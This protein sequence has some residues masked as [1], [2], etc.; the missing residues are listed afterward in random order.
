[1]PRLDMPSGPSNVP[2]DEPNVEWSS[3]EAEVPSERTERKGQGIREKVAQRL[4]MMELVDPSLMRAARTHKAIEALAQECLGI[5][6]ESRLDSSFV[7]QEI[8]QFWSHSWHGSAW[9]K[10]L[11]VLAMENGLAATV[12]GTLAGLIAMVLYINGLLPGGA[13]PAILG[14]DHGTSL[15]LWSTAAA[16]LTALLTLCFWRPPRSV[17]L[18]ALCVDRQTPRRKAECIVS[19]GAFVKRSRTLLVLWDHTFCQ[20]LWCIFEIGA[21]LKSHEENTAARMLVRPTYLGPCVFSLALGMLLTMGIMHFIRWNNLLLAV[22]IFAGWGYF[23]FSLAV[24]AFRH[25]FESVRV[26]QRC[27]ANFRIEDALCY[28]CQKAHRRPD[29]T[30][31]ICDREIVCDCIKRWYGSAAEFEERVQSTI[32]SALTSQLGRHAFPYLWVLGSTTP[33]LWGEMDLFAAHYQANW[34]PRR[35]Y[36][37]VIVFGWWLGGF[38]MIMCLALFVSE[39]C[40][41]PAGSKM[42][43]AL[44]TMAVT[45][46]VFPAYLALFVYQICCQRAWS[47]PMPGAILWALTTS[48]AAVLL[49]H[50]YACLRIFGMRD[51]KPPGVK[52]SL[53]Q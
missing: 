51:K 40:C 26:T 3:V 46:I 15:S 23:G 11:L 16:S 35:L 13:R 38:P 44:Q 31:I 37:T 2:S 18:D 43:D 21:F 24:H 5:E 32:S 45:L 52:H 34:Q 42:W 14:G 12:C 20:R 6:A 17:F 33:M 28:C 10:L 53:D 19:L 25:Y 27:M 29:G 8:C 30:K 49:W 4:E 41:K 47:E 7:V 22:M 1:M 50:P 9:K 39:R 36:S 48:P